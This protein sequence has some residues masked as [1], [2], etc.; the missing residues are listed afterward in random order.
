MVKKQTKTINLHANSDREFFLIHGYTGSPTDFNHL[1][2]E[3]H[4]KFNANVKVICLKGHGTKVEDLDNVTYADFLNQT[5]KELEKDIKKGRKVIL[6]GVS[7]GA[8]L[9]LILAS[10]YPVKGV[11]D[12]C[13]PYLLRFPFNIK[14]IEF[15]G[16]YKKYWKKTRGVNEKEKRKDGFSYDFMHADGLKIVKQANIE[17]NKK[18]KEIKCPI[19]SIHS[20]TDPI[21]HF[22]SLKAIQKKVKSY[23][24]KE[25]FL[26]TRIHNVFFS[27]NNYETYH[28]IIDFVKDNKLFE[29][30]NNDKVAA[31]IPSFNESERI[32][33]VLD[34]ITN[35]K[36]IN[37]IIVVNDGSTDNT[38]EIVKNYKKIKYVKNK[39]NIGKAGSMDKAVSLTNAGIIF[40]CDADLNG[41]TTEI[42]S[43]IIEPVKRGDFNMFIGVRGNFMQKTVHLFAINSGERAI[44]RIVWEKLPKYFKYK[45]RI[46]A[47]LNYF[48][49]SHFGGFGYKTFNY[50]QP[51]KE[52]KYGFLKGTVLRWA[53]NMDVLSVYIRDFFEK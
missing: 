2:N 27:M 42:I 40:F 49:N 38:E 6:G 51:I 11:F 4:K 8:L 52:K 35:S 21:G 17:L 13:P 12:V 34:V 14:N 22:K 32:G 3:L 23:L 28:S 45:Y 1:P 30:N 16:K 15:L 25:K 33:N 7:L 29:K 47:G 19:L 41:L 31:I 20:Y 37:E 10:E 48:V 26:N 5:K 53:M 50:S 36:I 9:A 18:L 46:E 39:K 43:G 44:R 24:K